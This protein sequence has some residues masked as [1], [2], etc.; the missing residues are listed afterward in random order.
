MQ[1]KIKNVYVDLKWHHQ[2]K[3]KVGGA[4]STHVIMNKCMHACLHA[5]TPAY[6]HTHMH[7]RTGWIGVCVCV[8][9]FIIIWADCAPPNFHQ[10]DGVILNL[11]IHSFFFSFLHQ[12]LVALFF[13]SFF[14][15]YLLTPDDNYLLKVLVFHCS[16]CFVI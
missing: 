10:V 16:L 11:H 1:K 14:Y 5:C 3:T 9:L 15:Y 4:W 12:L 2:N 13:A 7:T 6:S 8:C